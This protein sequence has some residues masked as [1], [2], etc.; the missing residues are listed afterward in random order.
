MV[1][2]CCN[3]FFIFFVVFTWILSRNKAK[4]EGEIL[5]K[6][7]NALSKFTELAGHRDSFV[8]KDFS[9]KS[10]EFTNKYET[11]FFTSNFW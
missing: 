9:D 3:C 5:K 11:D 4:L 8:F 1:I 2:K 10:C 7:E 6:V